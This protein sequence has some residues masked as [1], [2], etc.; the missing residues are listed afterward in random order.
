[1]EYLE[2]NIRF[3]LGQR[4]ISRVDFYELSSNSKKI[5]DELD[6]ERFD[7]GGNRDCNVSYFQ[8]I[9]VLKLFPELPI[10]IKHDYIS[11]F[12]EYYKP[13]H[14]LYFHKGQVLFENN[15]FETIKNLSNEGTVDILKYLIMYFGIEKYFK[16][17][18]D[19]INK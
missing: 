19:L 5:T 2:T 6:H 18:F 12:N 3:I 8:N 16:S 9:K 15:N 10:K 17:P 1:M 11:E 13:T 14:W 4:F 7:M